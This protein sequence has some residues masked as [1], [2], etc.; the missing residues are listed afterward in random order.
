MGLFIEIVFLIILV[1]IVLINL[2][3]LKLR[4]DLKKLENESKLSGMEIARIISSKFL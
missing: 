2:A 1:I 4:K 3:L